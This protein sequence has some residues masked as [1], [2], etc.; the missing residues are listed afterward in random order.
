MWIIRKMKKR[1]GV[2]EKN[3]NRVRIPKG[4]SATELVVVDGENLEN[5]IPQKGACLEEDTSPYYLSLPII[6]NTQV[7]S[8]MEFLSLVWI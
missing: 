4:I 3:V 5:V 6:S 1:G 8:V 7:K 2:M